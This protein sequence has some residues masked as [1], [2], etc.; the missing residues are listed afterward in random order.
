VKRLKGWPGWAVLVVV[1]AGLLAVGATRDDGPRTAAERAQA[2]AERVACPNCEGETVAE[3]RTGASQSIRVV[4]RELV[5]EGTASDEQILSYLET[6]YGQRILLVPR[7]TG[8]DALVWALP[9][10]GLV[11][12]L[13]ALTAT[14]LRWRREAAAHD[15][16]DADRALVDAALHADETDDV[17]ESAAP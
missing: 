9:V 1:L 7:A 8:F 2:L 6:N 10:A 12:A 3:S 14:F 5:D 4:I 11:C 13:A 15:P 17:E 16:T